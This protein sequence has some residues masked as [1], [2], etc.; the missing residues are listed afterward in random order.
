[1]TLLLGLAFSGLRGGTEKV[2]AVAG[3]EGRDTGQEGAGNEVGFFHGFGGDGAGE[4]FGEGLEEESG[5]WSLAPASG[6]G[7]LRG[8]GWRSGMGQRSLFWGVSTFVYTNPIFGAMRPNRV[9]RSV[10]NERFRKWVLD[11]RAGFLICI[12]KT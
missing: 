2:E 11:A 6:G 10:A 9:L 4:V 1:L 3:L 5:V 12:Y 7:R 8:W